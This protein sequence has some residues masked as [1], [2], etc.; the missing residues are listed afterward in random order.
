[1]TRTGSNPRRSTRIKR[2]QNKRSQKLPHLSKRIK[3]HPSHRRSGQ[4][5]ELSRGNSSLIAAERPAV[6]LSRLVYLSLSWLLNRGVREVTNW[7]PHV[8]D[9]P[10]LANGAV[11]GWGHLLDGKRAIN[12]MPFLFTKWPH[13]SKFI[14]STQARKSCQ[15]QNPVENRSITMR[16]WTILDRN[17]FTYCSPC[18]ITFTVKFRS[19]Y[20]FLKFLF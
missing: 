4:D 17:I 14:T 19:N 6:I 7:V 20:K 13:Y 5:I 18:R 9:R 10:L 3:S 11:S 15:F 2:I 16:Y 12:L 1:M 8:I